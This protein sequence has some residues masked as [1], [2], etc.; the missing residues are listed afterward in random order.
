LGCGSLKGKDG[1]IIERYSDGRERVRFKTVP[2]KE[3][4]S[5]MAT[6][7]ANWR[8]CLDERWAHPMVAMAAFNLDFLCIHPFRD[9]NGRVSRLLLLLPLLLSVLCGFSW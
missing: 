9:G 1:D 2:A 4:E 8:H 3:T 5:G 6:L 7:V